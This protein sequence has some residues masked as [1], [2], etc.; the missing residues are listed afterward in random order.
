MLHDA[1][2][3]DT[4]VTRADLRGSVNPAQSC[5]NKSQRWAAPGLEIKLAGILW[6][7]VKMMA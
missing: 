7:L 6:G 2:V 5:R 3:L 4:S 1:S